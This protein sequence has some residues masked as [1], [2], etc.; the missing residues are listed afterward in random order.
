MTHFGVI[1]KVPFHPMF[2]NRNGAEIKAKMEEITNV[3]T[4][5]QDAIKKFGT[6]G[7]VGAMFTASK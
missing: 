2:L 7:W 4:K 3:I 6:K 1:D 5:V